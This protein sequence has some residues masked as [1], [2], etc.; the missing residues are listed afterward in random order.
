MIKGLGYHVVCEGVE[1]REQSDILKEAGCE[2]GQG[3]LFAKPLP[4]EEYEQ[5]VYHGK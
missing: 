1:T 5:F 4:I 3:F 2:Q